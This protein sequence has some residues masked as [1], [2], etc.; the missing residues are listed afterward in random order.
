MHSPSFGE[1]PLPTRERVLER[2]A[3]IQDPCSVAAHRAMDIVSMGLIGQ[4]KIDG[5][6]V[7]LTLVL[8]EPVCWFSKDLMAF[9]EA[10]MRA[11]PGVQQA[12]VRL[13]EETIWTP[14]RMTRALP[15][16]SGIPI[17]SQRPLPT[18]A[19]LHGDST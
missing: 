3:E 18:T 17:V 7:S 19:D 15:L 9:A 5:R 6:R 13:D 2:L 10:K 4:L 11:V 14:D 16:F 12:D 1:P 8:T